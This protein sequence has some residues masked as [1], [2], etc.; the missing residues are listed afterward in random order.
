MGVELGNLAGSKDFTDDSK[1]SADETVATSG[2]A[3]IELIKKVLKKRLSI[4][5]QR[6]IQIFEYFD[7]NKNKLNETER[8]AGIPTDKNY[9]SINE[10]IKKLKEEI[11]KSDPNSD[12]AFKDF[13]N[14]II[15]II[16]YYKF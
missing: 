12:D 11:D 9:L 16:I 3:T 5:Y 10:K 13:I 6:I 8:I 15:Q 7:K 1:L 14:C 4:I 2:K